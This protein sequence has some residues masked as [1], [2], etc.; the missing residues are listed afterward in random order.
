MSSDTKFHVF[1]TTFFCYEM[2]PTFYQ[3]TPDKLENGAQHAMNWRLIS[4]KM[5]SN[6]VVTSL[7]AG[8]LYLSFFQFAFY[9]SLS[10][11]IISISLAQPC[12][13]C[14][15][16]SVSI[17]VNVRFTTN[18]MC[19]KK[20]THVALTSRNKMSTTWDLYCCLVPQWEALR[21]CCSAFPITTN[22]CFDQ[23][24]KVVPGTT[25]TKRTCNR[26]GSLQKREDVVATYRLALH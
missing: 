19:M 7:I 15:S 12:C 8:Y 3:M 5:V 4:K 18:R 17:V 20:N 14:C 10:L 24:M 26:C 11:P 22:W 13:K 2:S 1:S 21:I 9:L 23:N 25:F 6:V 16:L